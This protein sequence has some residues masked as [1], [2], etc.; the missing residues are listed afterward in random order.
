[1]IKKENEPYD[2][3]VQLNEL[4]QR[5]SRIEHYFDNKKQFLEGF[6]QWLSI[7]W[8]IALMIGIIVEI[9]IKAKN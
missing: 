9:W 4:N 1:M 2:I 3:S 6:D 7:G 8:K 5:L